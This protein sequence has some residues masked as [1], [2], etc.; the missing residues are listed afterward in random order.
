MWEG[1]VENI[2][3]YQGRARFQTLDSRRIERAFGNNSNDF[4]ISYSMTIKFTKHK[5]LQSF[6]DGENGDIIL[7]DGRRTT[8]FV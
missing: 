5:L 4:R 2:E 6:N 1:I 7:L 3:N 8:D